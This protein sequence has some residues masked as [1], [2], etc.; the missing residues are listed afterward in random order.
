MKSIKYQ[1]S[2]Q[3]AGCEVPP[4]PP[5]R[6]S[7]QRFYSPRRFA[8]PPAGHHDDQ[9]DVNDDQSEDHYDEGVEDNADHDHNQS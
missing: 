6:I 1:P 5:W 7:R 8:S 4:Q 2:D 3:P 9:N